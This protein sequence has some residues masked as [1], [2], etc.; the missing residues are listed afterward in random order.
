MSARRSL[1]ATLAVMVAAGVAGEA[2]DR[3]AIATGAGRGAAVDLMVVGRS[4]TLLAPRRVGLAGTSVAVAG[5][6][7][8]IAAATPLAE[9]ERAARASALNVVLHD[10]GHCGA[11]T[12]DAA[13]LFVTQV[14]GDRN[15]GPNGW[16]YKVNG[17]AGSTGAADPGGPFGNGRR[18]RG[19][20]QL[21]WF[22]C[23]AGAGQHCQRTLAIR[24]PDRTVARAAAVRVTVVGADDGGHAVAIAGAEVTLA[25][26]H[27]TTGPSGSATLTAPAAPGRYVVAATAPGLVPA[28]PAAVVIR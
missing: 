20:D 26:A 16:V 13:S 17:R 6:R 27:A 23:N 3:G 4:R 18:L 24:L 25:S 21:V 22:W 5:R 28:F 19:G 1:S 14:A 10:Y 2:L 15:S 7:C 9:L 12:A 8:T 11:A